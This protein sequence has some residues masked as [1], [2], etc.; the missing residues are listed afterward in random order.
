MIVISVVAIVFWA[1]SI[2]IRVC[3]LSSNGMRKRV[4][5]LAEQFST[6][7]TA[8]WIYQRSAY[9]QFIQTTNT[10]ILMPFEDRE[11]TG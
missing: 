8:V 1:L 3:L 5:T 11:L 4:Y 6:E 9:I 10:H 7:W 2:F